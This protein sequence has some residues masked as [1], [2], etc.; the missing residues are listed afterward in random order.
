M[1]MNNYSYMTLLSDDSYI[2][3]II[4]LDESLKRVNT[5]YPLEVLVTSNVSAPILNILDQRQLKYKI[6]QPLKFDQLFKHNIAINNRFAKNWVFTMTKFELFKMTDFDKLIF[7][8]ADIMVLKNL[9]H[10]FNKPHLTAAIDGEYFNIWPDNPHF[11]AGLLVIEPNI[12]EYNNLINFVT[13]FSIDSTTTTCIADQEILNAYYNQW[14][15]STDLHLNKYY[16]IFAPYIQDNQVEDIKQNAYFIHFIGRKPWRAFHKLDTETYTE[17]FYT[18][19]HQ[20]I[21]EEVN[22][23]NWDEAKAQLKIAVYGIC[24]DEKKNIE[25]Y[26]QCF[27]KADYLCILDTG[28]TDGTWEYLQEAAQKY[29]N[30]I[31][32]QKTFTPWRY[33]SARNYSLT[34]VPD[35]TVIYFMADLD[36]IIKTE[37]WPI[38]IKNAWNPLFSRGAYIYNRQVDPVTDTII[39]QFTEYRI[40]SKIWHYQGIVHEQLCDITNMRMFYSDECIQV[41]LIVWHYPTNPNRIAYIE[42]CEQGIQEEPLNWLMHLQLAAEYEIHEQY[43]NAIREYRI[44]LAEQ[45]NLSNIELGRCYASLG[46]CLSLLHKNDESL[47]VLEKGRELVPE[48]SD[49]YFFAA[50]INYNLHNFQTAFNLCKLGLDKCTQSYWCTIINPQG[51]FPY[52]LMGLSA[53][54]LNQKVLGLG[55]ITLAKTKNNSQEINNIFNW[56]IEEINRG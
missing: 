8:D 1:R 32:Q 49:C 2:F 11:N 44:I 6:I 54:Y 34:L 20:L 23:L 10:L 9:D 14:I 25:K 39:Q 46:R 19:A 45:Q 13:N 16:N 4:L 40:H 38:I 18:S 35:D 5:Q 26:I 56:M 30:L 3:G 7:L 37:N 21:Q 47:A 22:K 17:Y 24:K 43:D 15:T 29:S 31:I 55:Y 51:Y 27:S 28:S 50:E 36:E 42:L 12:E 53:F 52:F 41:P 33:D 48:Y